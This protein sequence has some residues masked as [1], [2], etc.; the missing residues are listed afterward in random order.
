MILLPRLLSFDF[1]L[2]NLYRLVFYCRI[3]HSGFQGF[4]GVLLNCIECFS[5]L[6]LLTSHVKLSMPSVICRRFSK[7]GPI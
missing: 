2:H 4:M 1:T 6:C 3:E 5:R 7:G